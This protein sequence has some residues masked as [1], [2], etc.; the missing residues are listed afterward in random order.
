MVVDDNALSRQPAL[1]ALHDPDAEEPA[2][3][4]AR[5]VGV[6][7]IELEG[8]VGCLVNGAGLAMATMDVIELLRRRAGELPRHRRGSPRQTGSTPRLRILLHD[9]YVR[10]V[11]INIFGGITRCDVVAKAVARRL[12]GG[13]DQSPRCGPAGRDQRRGGA[14]DARR[15]RGRAGGYHDRSRSTGGGAGRSG[16]PPPGASAV[17][18]LDGGQAAAS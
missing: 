18:A 1:A 6:S 9:P 10:A 14:P 17:P 13:G 12:R 5:Q 11:L 16:S 4:E 7:Y 2:E 8:N 15:D 3:A